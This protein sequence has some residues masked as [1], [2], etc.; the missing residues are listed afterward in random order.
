MS[1]SKPVKLPP[2]RERAALGIAIGE[3]YPQVQQATGSLVGTRTSAATPLAPCDPHQKAKK[4]KVLPASPPGMSPQLL[5]EMLP[6]AKAY[7]DVF[8]VSLCF[9]VRERTGTRTR[10]HHLTAPVPHLA[11]PKWGIFWPSDKIKWR[12]S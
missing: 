2:M 4:G 12:Y 6:N 9:F 1:E 5:P 10:D 7:A 8:R 11:T 3:L